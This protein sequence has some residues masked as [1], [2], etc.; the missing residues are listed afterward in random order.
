MDCIASTNAADASLALSVLSAI[1]I[2]CML[3]L[4][5]QRAAAWNLNANEQHC[6]TTF[7]A[8]VIACQVLFVILF[9]PNVLAPPHGYVFLVM[10]VLNGMCLA[11]LMAAVLEHVRRC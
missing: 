3:I 6:L 10:T 4:R 8:G 5:I 11:T 7:F 2:A 9:Y 1:P